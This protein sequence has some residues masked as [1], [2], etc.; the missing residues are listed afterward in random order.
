M[1]HKT[2]DYQWACLAADPATF[3]YQGQ[4]ARAQMSA[5][6]FRRLGCSM[7]WT[8]TEWS[9]DPIVAPITMLKVYGWLP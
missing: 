3:E 2:P 7:I 8:V 9:S 6:A 5:D 1:I 4:L